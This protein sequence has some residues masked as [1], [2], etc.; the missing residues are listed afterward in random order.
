MTLQFDLLP[1]I[2]MPPLSSVSSSSS[3]ASATK[4]VYKQEHTTPLCPSLRH[5]CCPQWTTRFQTGCAPCTNGKFAPF[6]RENLFPAQG[7]FFLSPEKKFSLPSTLGT[8]SPSPA[9]ALQ[10]HAP[11]PRHTPTHAR[12]R[13]MRKITTS[14]A[15]AT[16]PHDDD[17]TIKTRLTCMHKR[18][19]PTMTP[20]TMTPMTMGFARNR[21]PSLR[22]PA[23]QS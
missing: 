11:V 16:I 23:S 21:Y 22:F 19:A 1:K 12:R 6:E 2:Q 5:S 20:M 9:C 10:T 18:L 8:P 7:K 17:D 13:A 15:S 3:R 4:Y 14:H